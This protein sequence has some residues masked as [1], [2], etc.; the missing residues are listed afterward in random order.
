MSRLAYSSI[1]RT[2]LIEFLC[3]WGLA[4]THPNRSRVRPESGLISVRSPMGPRLA[5]VEGVWHTLLTHSAL[6]SISA[7]AL[8]GGLVRPA[9]HKPPAGG[10]LRKSQPS[11]SFGRSRRR[12]EIASPCISTAWPIREAMARIYMLSRKRCN[13]HS[14]TTTQLQL[15]YHVSASP[16]YSRM[17]TIATASAF[18]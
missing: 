15:R 7:V 12:C 6:S 16:V 10:R 9:L 13:L 18:R 1:T 3:L 2:I 11:V 8:T 5:R 4:I 17:S 14:C